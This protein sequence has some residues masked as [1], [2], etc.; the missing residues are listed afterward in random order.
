MICFR[1]LSVLPMMLQVLL[2]STWGS[3]YYSG[4]GV[5]SL[6]L[7]LPLPKVDALS[8]IISAPSLQVNLSDPRLVHVHWNNN[9]AWTRT[10]RNATVIVKAS[11]INNF[12]PMLTHHA[13]AP[14]RNGVLSMRLPE[15][16]FVTMYYFTMGVTTPHTPVSDNDTS[17]FTIPDKDFSPITGKWPIASDCDDFLNVANIP[18][19]FD[20]NYPWACGECP[21]GASCEYADT[22]ADIKPR[23]SFQR[24]D[25]RLSRTSALPLNASF[26]KCRVPEA[27]LGMRTPKSEVPENIYMGALRLNES[28]LELGPIV[29]LARQNIAPSRCNYE[30]GYTDSLL[31]ERCGTGYVKL[32][33]TNQCEQ[34]GLKED[35]IWFLV[36]IGGTI[37]VFLFLMIASRIRS[38]S[39]RRYRWHSSIK[40]ICITHIQI[41]SYIMGLNVPWPEFIV[42]VFYFFTAVVSNAAPIAATECLLQEEGKF[43]G[44][45]IDQIDYV[46]IG[47][48]VNNFFAIS[49]IA[50]VLAPIVIIVPVNMVY[51]IVLSPFNRV[52]SCGRKIRIATCG[53]R[54]NKQ[55]GSFEPNRCTS[56]CI[57]CCNTCCC[58]RCC[59]RLCEPKKITFERYIPSN[60]DAFVASTILVLYMILPSIWRICFSALM[61]YR[62]G[63]EVF[64]SYDL[65]QRWMEGDHLLLVTCAVI[66]SMFLYML[67]LPIYT[68]M[69][70]KRADR[71]S[72]TSSSDVEFKARERTR[73]RFGFLYLG[74]RSERWWWEGVQFLKK[75]LIVLIVTFMDNEFQ[76]HSACGLFILVLHAQHRYDPYGPEYITVNEKG[77]DEQIRVRGRYVQMLDSTSVI[78]LLGTMWSAVFFYFRLC[79][80][81]VE[82]EYSC[83]AL[84]FLILFFNCGIVA[85]LT[86]VA[87]YTQTEIIFRSVKRLRS[88]IARKSVGK[89]SSQS[90]SEAKSSVA[91]EDGPSNLTFTNPMANRLLDLERGGGKAESK[92]ASGVAEVEMTEAKMSRD[93]HSRSK[94]IGVRLARQSKTSTGHIR[95]SSQPIPSAA[96]MSALPVGWK[97]LKTTDGRT[98]FQKPDGSTTWKAPTLPAPTDMPPPS[99]HGL[100]GQLPPPPPPL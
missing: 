61:S 14:A 27:C 4:C 7:L 17:T 2:S 26:H 43:A 28:S 19:P 97:A 52:F 69:K 1:L 48:K 73:F 35:K 91:A 75:I 82:G 51:W 90:E 49:L 99:P 84:S 46:P 57:S 44:I 32:T 9:T 70:L 42:M 65:E 25:R 3:G 93:S 72:D 68:M 38:S 34:C 13:H 6:L 39:Q 10:P 31:C 23:F 96:R 71:S 64:V 56:C 87:L 83:H 30:M 59:K 15:S 60:F 22:D 36:G 54:K 74:Y 41:L 53:R 40:R 63:D 81:G 33:S 89:R 45:S 79:N 50:L 24:V 18:N 88:S 67:V 21:T 95:T 76:I 58:P 78:I 5:L 62:V 100:L 98:Y 47:I 77:I 85:Y 11:K 8:P 20:A 12:P 86:L 94:S 29:D 55:T 16:T 66:P 92:V 37:T 80:Q